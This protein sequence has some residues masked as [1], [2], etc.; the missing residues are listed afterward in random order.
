MRASLAALV[1]A[2]AMV[3]L[4]GCTQSDSAF[5]IDSDAA[6]DDASFDANV[7]SDGAI[8]ATLDATSDAGDAGSDGA[9]DATSE[10]SGDASTEASDARAEAAVDAGPCPGTAGPNAVRVGAYCIDVTEVTNANYTQFL[11]ADAGALPSPPAACAGNASYVPGAGTWPPASGHDNDPV[12]AVDWCD[13]YVYCAWAGKRLCGAIG[14]GATPFAMYADSSSSAW[15]AACSTGGTRAYP[16]GGTY[17]V[18][19]CS[20]KDYPGGSALRPVGTLATC[21]GGASAALRDMSGN[22]YEWEDSC[23]ANVGATDT[24]HI[25]GGG[26][27]TPSPPGNLNLSCA[28]SGVALARGSATFVDVGFRCCGP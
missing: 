21:F 17:D 24:C 9:A 18:A 28:G 20:G 23:D 22:V 14:G 16:Y 8:D 6:P 1:L 15:F 19:A 2:A 27:L 12:V 4:T 26:Y 10:A 25:R 11:A 3:S 5:S 13:A 7:H